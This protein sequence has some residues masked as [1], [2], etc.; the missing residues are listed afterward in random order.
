MVQAEFIKN[1]NIRLHSLE[2]HSK[3][4]EIWS[5]IIRSNSCNWAIP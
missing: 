1:V 4:F 3:Y 2:K 5:A